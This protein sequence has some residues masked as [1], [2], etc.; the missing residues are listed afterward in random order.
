MAELTPQH[1]Q[2]AQHMHT[3]V[4]PHCRRVCMQPRWSLSAA[5]ATGT[6]EISRGAWNGRGPS[7]QHEL[8]YRTEEPEELQSREYEFDGMER[9]LRAF[10]G[11]AAAWRSGGGGDEALAAE[12]AKGSPEEALLDLA[13]LEAM[14]QSAKQGAVVEVAAVP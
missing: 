12:V 8:T 6:L 11:A 9:E 4:T 1:A 2:H 13:I 7:T 3:T 10:V 5:G 14:I